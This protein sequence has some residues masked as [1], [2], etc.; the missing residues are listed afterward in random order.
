MQS[1]TKL[2]ADDC[3][4][5]RV[6]DSDEDSIILQND[7]D[8]I[9]KWCTDWQMRF[10]DDK[11]KVLE[12]T[13]KRKIS[14]QYKY[15]LNGT[16]LE[17]VTHHP[18]LGV[19]LSSNLSWTNHVNKITSKASKSLNL[20]RRNFYKFPENI[21][22]Q[23]YQSIIRPTMEYA[24]SCWDPYEQGHIDQLEK[25]Q[26]KAA[27]FIKSDYKWTSSVSTLKRDL[28]LEPLQRRRFIARNN[29]F[30]KALKCETAI[31]APFRDNVHHIQTNLDSYKYSF[32][33]RTARCWNIIPPE[34]RSAPTSESFKGKLCNAFDTGYLKLVKPKTIYDRPRYGMRPKTINNFI[35]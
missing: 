28:E 9:C 7:L 2:F 27:R 35:Y 19:E 21:K 23:A 33:P 13:N 12:I 15:N 24:A 22:K 17:V 8:K 5:F 11:C 4:L 14:N 18:Y 1:S 25:I 26:N 32:I 10:N 3:L 31:H 34:V 30:Y 6:I 20:L 29:A 16:T